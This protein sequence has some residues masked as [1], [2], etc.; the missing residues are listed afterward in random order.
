MH[1]FAFVHSQSQHMAVVMTQPIIQLLINGVY[2]IRKQ[3]QLNH[4]FY[5]DC[6]MINFVNVLLHKPQCNLS[7]MCLTETSLTVLMSQ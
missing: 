2:K 6:D 4:A 3:L 1:A 7:W 5:Y